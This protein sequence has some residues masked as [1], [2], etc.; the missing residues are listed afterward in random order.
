MGKANSADVI[1]PVLRD[2]II[3]LKLRPGAMLGENPLA[4]RFG[5]SRTII[6]SVLQRLQENGFVCIIP[7]VGT[8]VTAIDLGEVGDFIYLRVAVESA[9]LRDFLHICTPF[10]LEE[11]RS[12]LNAL[13]QMAARIPDPAART[14]DYT[15]ACLREDLSFHEC[16]FRATNHQRLWEQLIGPR[17]GYSRFIQLDMLEGK[18]LPEVLTEH[19]EIMRIVDGRAADRVEACLANHLHGGVRRLSGKLF[20]AEYAGYFTGAA[21]LPAP[22]QQ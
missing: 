9:V 3:S 8:Q 22:A 10:Q 4:E 17:P 18:N 19:R 2:E 12:H 16:Y 11:M 1:Y 15:T 21:G 6:R 14:E 5:V 13:E 20:A 7:Y